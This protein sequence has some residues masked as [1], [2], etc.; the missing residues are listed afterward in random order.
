MGSM[1]E[2]STKSGLQLQ[3]SFPPL[4]ARWIWKQT[5]QCKS[6]CQRTH[7]TT[8]GRRRKLLRVGFMKKCFLV[9]LYCLRLYYRPNASSQ[10]LAIWLERGRREHVEEFVKAH[11]KTGAGKAAN[12]LQTELKSFKGELRQIAKVW[13]QSNERE[14]R[15][16]QNSIEW[17]ML[18]KSFTQQFSTTFYSVIHSFIH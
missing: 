16:Q 8:T 6:N 13:Y 17:S 11:I 9:A 1:L 18:L 12:V 15:F 3:N 4:S 5:Q 10:Q 2:A 7:F 14:K